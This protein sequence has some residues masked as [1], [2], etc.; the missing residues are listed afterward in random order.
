MRTTLELS[1]SVVAQ[2]RALSGIVRISDLVRE[3]LQALIAREARKRLVSFG[4]SDPDA[5]VADRRGTDLV[6]ENPLPR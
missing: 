2:A 4:G 5:R 3:G 6:A 1:D